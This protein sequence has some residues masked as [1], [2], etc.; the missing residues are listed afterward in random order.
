MSDENKVGTYPFVAEPLHVDFH[1]NP[2]DGSHWE[3]IC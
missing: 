1:G 3:I 2:D